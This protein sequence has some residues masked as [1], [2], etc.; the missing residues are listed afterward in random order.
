MKDAAERNHRRAYG[1]NFL[2]SKG[3]C[4]R[5]VGEFLS[6]KGVLPPETQLLE[7][8]PG[9]GAL[10]GLL[11]RPLTVAEADPDLVERWRAQAE[12]SVVPGD[13]V[14]SIPEWFSTHSDSVAVLANL[15]YNASTAILGALLEHAHR[16]PLMVL[17]FQKEVAQKLRA[18]PGEREV[19]PLSILSQNFYDLARLLQVSPGSFHPR[20]NVDSEVLVFSRL[21]AP[22]FS[23]AAKLKNLAFRAF[24]QRR[25]MLRQNLKTVPLALATR[26]AHELSWQDWGT[27]LESETA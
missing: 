16:V 18:L 15:P 24:S 4:E 5:I 23:D 6:R 8:G 22:R 17:M 25:K 7:I 3:V 1:Q 14:R 20:P 12:V 13:A 9:E 27:L 19:G 10:T 26:R 2:V 11:P 21:R